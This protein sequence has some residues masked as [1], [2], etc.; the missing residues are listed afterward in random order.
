L[1]GA[2]TFVFN[3]DSGED[4]IFDFETGKDTIIYSGL[5]STDWDLVAHGYDAVE[6]EYVLDFGALGGGT[7][8]LHYVKAL[9]E[10]DFI[11]V[12]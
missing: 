11:L 9:I 1:S 10:G 6:D 2:D 4:E 7:L 12:A 8:T 3:G 5:S